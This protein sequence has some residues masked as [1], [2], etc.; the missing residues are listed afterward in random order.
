MVV[1]ER[2]MTRLTMAKNHAI[3]RKVYAQV[4]READIV[5]TPNHKMANLIR[6]IARTGRQIDVI[7]DPGNTGLN[8]DIIPNIPE[9]QITPS[10][11]DIENTT[12]FILQKPERY[13][14]KKIILSVGALIERKGHEYLIKA[15]NY[16]KDEFPDIKCIIIGGGG[17]LRSL[18]KL[19]NELSLNNIVELYGKRPH[20]EVL[21]T[22]S[23][24]DV[25]VQPSW[26]EPFGTVY[27]EAMAFAKPI[28]A[29]SEEG[30]C[31]VVQDGVQGLLVRKQD[32]N[33]LADALKKILNDENL[34][35]RLGRAA[36]VLASEQLN[37]NFIA[38]RMIDLYKQIII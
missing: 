27:A 8:E 36:K 29:C 28:I 24:C 4:I 37:Y 13:K 15:I 16:I 17:R 3:R 14:G 33:S 26:D 12:A 31:E 5:L 30:I 21:K 20:D 35:S 1:H 23:W 25:F 7:R 32:V 10:A 6:E 19:I 38:T 11:G 34:A 9:I 22:M 18:E 2:S